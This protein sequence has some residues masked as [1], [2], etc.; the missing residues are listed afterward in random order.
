MENCKNCG[1]PKKIIHG[2]K[3]CP[4]CYKKTQD[5]NYQKR[6]AAMIAAHRENRHIV[7]IKLLQY[8][9]EHPCVDCGE[10]NPLYLAFD[11]IS[12]KSY[13]ISRGIHTNKRWETLLKEIEK[14][15]VRCLRCHKLK[16]TY[17]NR[18][19]A[20]L[21]DERFDKLKEEVPGLEELRARIV[22]ATGLEPNKYPTQN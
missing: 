3:R 20:W 2:A 17:Q 11:H 9:I 6:K 5:R 7:K 22:A 16:T 19:H 10:T 14:C 13:C 12:D 8:L 18:E 21:F 1:T 15:E 4:V